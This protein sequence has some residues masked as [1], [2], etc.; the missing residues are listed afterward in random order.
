MDSVIEGFAQRLEK[1]DDF[2]SALDTLLEIASELGYTQV[3]YAYLPVSPRLPTGE[4]MPLKLNVRNFPE[5][6]EPGWQKFMTVDPYYRAC[7]HGTLPIDWAD[8]QG[9]GCLA[10]AQKA[11]CGYLADFGLSRGMTFPVHLPFGR[12]AVV[13]AIVDKSCANWPHIRDS[14]SE[15]MFRLTHC[16][17]NLVHE[18]GFEDQVAMV[19]PAL[20]TPREAECL[21]WASAGKT[22]SETAVILDRSI[23]TIRLHIK[24]AIVKLDA[25]NR[26]HAVAKAVHL[27]LLQPDMPI[28]A[29]RGRQASA[30]PAIS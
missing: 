16:F 18:R 7:F 9:D 12:F 2:S 5:G 22:S 6:W 11:A 1:A 27:G 19:L 13:S 28:P 24:N 4:W 23:E 8:V 20:L 25:S 30:P 21:F 10:P 26:S 3:L 14:T 15:T 29:G 17:H